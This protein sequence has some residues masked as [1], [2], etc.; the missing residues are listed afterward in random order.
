M[1]YAWP[2]DGAAVAEFLAEQISRL[3]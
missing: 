2:F 3:V 1:K